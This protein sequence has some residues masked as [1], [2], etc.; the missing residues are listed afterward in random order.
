MSPHFKHLYGILQFSD[1]AK[2]F[3]PITLFRAFVIVIFYVNTDVFKMGK[4][5]FISGF[6][7]IISGDYKYEK[8]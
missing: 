2:I 8:K 5:H 3:T 1:Y 7:F 6:L 4:A